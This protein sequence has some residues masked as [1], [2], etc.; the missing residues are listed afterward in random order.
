MKTQSFN[1]FTDFFQFYIQDELAPGINGESWTPEAM[2]IS[3]AVE[4][5]TVGIGTVRNMDA[6]VGIEIHEAVPK[7]NDNGWDHIVECGIDLPSGRLVIAGC[8]DY[9]PDAERI[10]LPKGQY[11]VR[12][13]YG[14]LNRVSEDGFDGD[15][16]YLIKLWPS[17]DVSIKIIQQKIK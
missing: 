9:F 1:I 3:L 5:N 7:G 12:V 4:K 17:T 10:E 8:S 6:P 15:D 13:Y 2:K 16:H 14:G 11:R